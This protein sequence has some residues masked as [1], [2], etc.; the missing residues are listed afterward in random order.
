L[1][2]YHSKHSRR[3]PTGGVRKPFRKKR[4]HKFGRDPVET[5]LGD[6][7]YVIVRGRG[8][9]RKIKT[10]SDEYANVCNPK[11]KKT[12]RS[13]ILKVEANP[14]NRDYDRRGVITRGAIIQTSDGKAVVTSRPGQQGIVNA[15][16]IES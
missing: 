11:E 14:S 1:P 5:T 13:K 8:S 4:K 3:R 15:K 16:I 9:N 10:L 2:Q 12:K 7:R 6:K